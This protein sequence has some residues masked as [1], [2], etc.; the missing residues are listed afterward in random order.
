MISCTSFPECYIGQRTNKKSPETFTFHLKQQSQQTKKN[1][2]MSKT[3]INNPKLATSLVIT[4]HDT[5]I[6]RTIWI[7]GDQFYESQLVSGHLLT[8]PV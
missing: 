1:K 8:D 4:L 3:K 5:I 6:V 7:Q 2:D